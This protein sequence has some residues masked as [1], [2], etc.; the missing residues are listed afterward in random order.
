MCVC[1]RRVCVDLPELGLDAVVRHI[2]PEPVRPCG[3]VGD[4][5]AGRGEIGKVDGW[6]RADYKA[7]CG[8]LASKQLAK[9][10]ERSL[11]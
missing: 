11:L 8:A 4:G 5:A 3:F 7:V 2:A 10:F 6:E 1:S 9:P